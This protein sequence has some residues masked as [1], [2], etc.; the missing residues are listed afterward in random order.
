MRK[1]WQVLGAATLLTAIGP[2]AQ[3]A[4]EPSVDANPEV[5]SYNCPE[6]YDIYP[7]WSVYASGTGWSVKYAGSSTWS[8]NRPISDHTESTTYHPH[9][10]CV[11]YTTQFRATSTGWPTVYDNVRTVA[12]VGPTR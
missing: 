9:Y 8:S 10:A 3:A 2:A 6:A 7:S 11:D 5:G 4:P 12:E 1:Y